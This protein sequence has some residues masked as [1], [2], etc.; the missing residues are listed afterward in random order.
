MLALHAELSDELEQTNQGV[1]ALYAELDEATRQLRAASESKTRFLGRCQ[2]RAAH[3]AQL[4]A[5]AGPLAA[6]CGVGRR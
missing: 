5:R 1:V 6:R 3:T 4:G 2:P